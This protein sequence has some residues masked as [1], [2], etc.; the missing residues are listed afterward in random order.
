MGSITIVGFGVGVAALIA[1]VALVV[2]IR[3]PTP[4]QFNVFRT[5]I[6]L[7][8]AGFAL[9]LT[10][11]LT[12]QLGSSQKSY[13]SAGGTLAVFVLLYLFSPATALGSQP[14][15]NRPNERAADAALAQGLLAGH[16]PHDVGEQ[17]AKY[18][19]AGE[20]LL[21][22]QSPQD[23]AYERWRTEVESY[24]KTVFA[25]RA[26]AVNP[27]EAFEFSMASWRGPVE[28]QGDLK[29]H[30]AAALGVLGATLV[31]LKSTR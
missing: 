19:T 10:G 6:A 14:E 13:I 7:G 18:V 25:K 2:I 26:D 28:K 21:D 24:L 31:N 30:L 20:F 23:A 4:A 22:S 3:N 16:A 1:V 5:V 12:V 15:A 11:L 9:S 29:Q 17:V 8:G 27:H